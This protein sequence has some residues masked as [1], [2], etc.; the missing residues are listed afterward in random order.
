M[1]E[2]ARARNMRGRGSLLRDEIIAAAES[3][4]DASGVAGPLTLRG[5][6]R[7]AGISA[8]S[9]YLHFVDV[10]AIEDALLERAFAELDGV[11]AAALAG[12]TAPADALV[13]G[14]LAY[15]KYAWDHRPRYRFMVAGG[16]FAPEAVATFARIEAALRECVASGIS[17]STDVHRDAFLIWVGMHGMA[18]LEKPDR[19]ELRRLGPLDRVAL[20]ETLART[21]A[22]LPP[23]R[24]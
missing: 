13:A 3:L 21:L 11:V 12:E 5:V 22:K 1:T 8:P 24:P 20:T 19:V 7:K 2:S 16:G 4:V 6:A 9:I 15:V 18:T 17:T 10:G 14:C 23:A